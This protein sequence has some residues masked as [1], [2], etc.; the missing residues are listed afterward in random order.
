MRLLDRIRGSEETERARVAKNDL[1]RVLD[2]L[3][4]ITEA[5]DQIA[6]TTEQSR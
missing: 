2:L 5:T 3:D 6:T 4:D 1:E